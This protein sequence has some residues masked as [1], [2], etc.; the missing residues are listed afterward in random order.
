MKISK[1][2]WKVQCKDMKDGD[3]CD[4]LKQHVPPPRLARPDKLS[5]RHCDQLTIRSCQKIL[6]LLMRLEQPLMHGGIMTGGKILLLRQRPSLT[7]TITIFS[8]CQEGFKFAIFSAIGAC[9]QKICPEGEKSDQLG[10]SYPC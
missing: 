1:R 10:F 5:M 4:I 3:R 7:V 8:Y 2:C 6:L 9:G